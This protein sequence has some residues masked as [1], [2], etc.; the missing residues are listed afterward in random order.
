[1]ARS[2][3]GAAITFNR[4][5]AL[6]NGL[7]FLRLDRVD[8]FREADGRYAVRVYKS[9][10]GSHRAASRVASAADALE[11]QQGE[12]QRRREEARQYQ[13]E[14]A[15]VR[16]EAEE[17]RRRADEEKRQREREEVER[18]RLA[19]IQRL[20]EEEKRVRLQVAED[21]RQTARDQTR[22]AREHD[23]FAAWMA[24]E[25]E[26]AAT[27]P[28]ATPPPEDPATREE[29]ENERREEARREAER[30]L[31]EMAASSDAEAAAPPEGEAG[32]DDGG[33]GDADA[34]REALAVLAQQYAREKVMETLT[35][36][37]EQYGV[38]LVDEKTL[39]DGTV[40][41]TLW[42]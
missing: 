23:A 12:V 15:R 2:R 13:E 16:R 35:R 8:F 4:D 21:A 6:G 41:I 29:R 34:S 17:R 37:E 25:A 32:A 28:V 7:S 14:M 42:G 31:A 27:T 38:R 26:S 18:L 10:F 24:A 40:Q 9:L 3:S 30:L 20:K 33:D 1:M 5:V 39:A 11:R 36:V 19:E 22:Q